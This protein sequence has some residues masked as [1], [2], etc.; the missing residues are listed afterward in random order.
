MLRKYRISLI[1]VLALVSALAGNAQGDV[2]VRYDFGADEATQTRNP[3]TVNAGVTATPITSPSA[4]YGDTAH[5]QGPVWWFSETNPAG[6]SALAMGRPGNACEP[7]HDT[8][9]QLSA[10]MMPLARHRRC[11]QT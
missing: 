9:G 5:V 11:H 3:A 1:V 10:A 7:A 2:L 8:A 4:G 6:G